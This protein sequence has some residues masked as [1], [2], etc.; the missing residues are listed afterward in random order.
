MNEHPSKGQYGSGRLGL[1]GRFRAVFK[2]CADNYVGI[3]TEK[4]KPQAQ[5]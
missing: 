5:Y 2:T 4:L 1:T 3:F